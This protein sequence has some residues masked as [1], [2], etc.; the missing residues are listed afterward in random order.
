[1]FNL[2]FAIHTNTIKLFSLFLDDRL[3]FFKS[4]SNCANFN[5]TAELVMPT[6]TPTDEPDAEIETQPVTAELKI[7]KCSK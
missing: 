4:C 5:P 7:R 2:V 1:M 3:I 6:G